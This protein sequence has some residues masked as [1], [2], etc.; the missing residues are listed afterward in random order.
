MTP[1]HE[2][3][4]QPTATRSA[5]LARARLLGLIRTFFARAGV[6]EVETPVLSRHATVDPQIE[7]FST[8]DGRWLQTSPEFAMK[9][10]LAAGSGPIFQ[11]A[12][13]FRCE[14]RGRYHNP[15]F[16][17]LEWYRPG[18]DLAQLMD[19][20]QALFQ[21]SGV[22]AQT[23]YPRLSYLQAFQRHAGL[24][25]WQTPLAGLI[26][27]ASGLGLHLAAEDPS[28]ADRDFWLDLLMSHR[29]GPALGHDTPVFLF[30]FPASQAS[31]ARVR[32]SDPPLAERFELFWQGV[33]LA[34]GF[35]E[36]ADADEQLR[37]FTEGQGLRARQGRV[38][39]PFDAHLISAL[40]AGLPDCAGVAVGVDRW[41]MLSLGVGELAQVLA[42]ADPRA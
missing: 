11:V 38:V 5:L 21:T 23:D 42:F 12:R 16:T 29:V 33:E 30:D 31:L 34:N 13:V 26:E 7:S 39:P 41:L 10:L 3:L 36:L 32:P 37:R 24:D 22:A 40:A 25:P 35:H 14:E 20:V 2:A 18:F 4:W 9:R 19:E 17:L 15:E 27:A 8:A 28:H 6:L 1:A